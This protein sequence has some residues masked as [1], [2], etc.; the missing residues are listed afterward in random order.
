[1]FKKI[2]IASAIL[3]L[4]FVII[5][6]TRPDDFRVKRSVTIPTAADWCTRR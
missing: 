3:I 2:L 4:V 6:L 5:V 1:M